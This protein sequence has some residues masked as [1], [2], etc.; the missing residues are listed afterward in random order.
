MASRI[1]LCLAVRGVAIGMASKLQNLQSLFREAAKIDMQWYLP[2]SSNKHVEGHIFLV[3]FSEG[4]AHT[5]S[6][7]P[8]TEFLDQSFRSGMA[9]LPGS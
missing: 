4:Q 9:V 2:C 5:H 1:L 7:L 6:D 3:A 8:A